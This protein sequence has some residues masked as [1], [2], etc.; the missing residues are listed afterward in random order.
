MYCFYHIPTLILI[1]FTVE[2][3][4]SKHIPKNHN[5]EILFEKYTFYVLFLNK[6][7]QIVFIR[8]DKDE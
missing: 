7:I 1:V 5:L 4:K 8:A 6:Y 2:H 3:M